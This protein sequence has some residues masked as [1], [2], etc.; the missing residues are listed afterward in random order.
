LLLSSSLIASFF[1]VITCTYVYTRNITY[2]VSIMLLV[3]MFS[4]W[5]FGIG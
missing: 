3:F 4:G 1:I 5:S 2:T